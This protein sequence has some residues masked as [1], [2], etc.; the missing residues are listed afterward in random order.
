MFQ[1]ELREMEAGPNVHEVQRHIGELRQQMV[2]RLE[3][4]GRGH[5]L[6]RCTPRDGIHANEVICCLNYELTHKYTML[7]VAH[8]LHMIFI[9]RGCYIDTVLFSHWRPLGIQLQ[10][11]ISF[12]TFS[13][14]N[15]SFVCR[16]K[17]RG[18]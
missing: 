12:F 8:A 16:V 2:L 3:F 13:E 11:S 9:G 6:V 14:D 1:P 4:L 10:V 15:V 18:A 5:R 7:Q 17:G